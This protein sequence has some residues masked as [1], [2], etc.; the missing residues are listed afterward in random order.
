MRKPNR[1]KNTFS[2]REDGVKE[3]MQLELDCLFSILFI[4]WPSGHVGF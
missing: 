1:Q 2:S 4:F 3:V